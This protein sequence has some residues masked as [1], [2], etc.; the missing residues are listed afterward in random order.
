MMLSNCYTQYVSQ[1][2]KCSSGHQTGKYV[3]HCNYK[4]KQCQR[5]FKILYIVLISHASKAVFKIFLVVHEQKT[6]RSTIWD[7]KRQ[8]N[9]RSNCQKSWII[10]K[11][12]KFQKK[13]SISVSLTMPK[14]LTVWVTTNYGKFLKRWNTRPPPLPPEK[15]VCRS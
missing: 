10:Q 6:S 13:T 5:M 14:P 3:F 7:Q 8:R 15:P 2:G 11:A 12:K 4:E 1:F 9:Q